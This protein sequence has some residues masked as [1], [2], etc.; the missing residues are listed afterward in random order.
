MSNRKISL[1]Y[2]GYSLYF[3]SM[4]I[5]DVNNYEVIFYTMLRYAS[6]IIFI[7]HIMITNRYNRDI[8]KKMTL[9]VSFVGGIAVLTHNIYYLGIS[10]AILA[11]LH[12]D[13]YK[14]I[15]TSFELLLLSSIFVAIL[16]MLGIIENISLVLQGI[17]RWGLGYYHSNVFPMIIFYL[18]SWRIIA[19]GKLNSFEI[20]LLLIS[21][22][23]VYIWCHSRNGL[24]TC[25]ILAI[26]AC[27]NNR[28]ISIRLEKER[29]SCF[30]LRLF[31]KYSILMITIFSL[32][33]TVFNGN[34]IPIIY[35]INRLFTGRFA[36]AYHKLN[37][38]GLHLI[39]F[40]TGDIYS[41]SQIVVDNGYMYVILRYG[42]VFILFYIYIQ[43]LICKKYDKLIC[44]VFAITSVASMV[45]N[46]L[47]SYGFYPYILLAFNQQQKST[48]KRINDL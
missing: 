41:L 36:L 3:L 2:L 6:Y 37:A 13:I 35:I 27:L 11:S 40:M 22:L 21:T 25:S 28:H 42:L 29:N 1:F 34:N 31:Y 20:F 14:I 48:I 9:F 12:E 15:N 19:N 4:F 17:M 23:S 47:F 33:L 18:F 5:Q 16:T 44:I 8:I 10:L 7:I 39:N 46:D 30:I 38:V 26:Y 43:Y 24:I 45:D 32:I